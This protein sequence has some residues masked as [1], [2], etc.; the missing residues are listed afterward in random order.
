M[1]LQEEVVVAEAPV[2]A[3]PPADRFAGLVEDLPTGPAQPGFTAR[4]QLRGRLFEPIEGAEQQV[5]GK[6]LALLASR[7]E[8]LRSIAPE[9]PGRRQEW[10]GVGEPRLD[11]IEIGSGARSAVLPAIEPASV[12]HL[13]EKRLPVLAPF[14]SD[15]L[16]DASP[17]RLL[18]LDGMVERFPPVDSKVRLRSPLTD[19]RGKIIG[20]KSVLR[21]VGRERPR[22]GVHAPAPEVARRLRDEVALVPAHLELEGKAAIE[23]QIGEHPLA[24]SVNREDVRPVDVLE[25]RV[26]P[27]S[28]HLRIDPGVFSPGG[29]ELR[30]LGAFV[31]PPGRE[32]SPGGPEGFPNPLAELGRSPPR[33]N[34]TT[35]TSVEPSALLHHEPGNDA[36]ELPGLARAGARFDEGH[37]GP[38]RSG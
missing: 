38:A 18:R 8:R 36:G 29:E 22:G 5:A 23:G 1:Q 3:D 13:V 9:Q 33:V 26:E 6:L 21:R 25:S 20:P 10:I 19:P 17:R 27:P 24:K 37:A 11:R 7:G 34:V 14:G 28:R 35:R 4:A 12:P 16:H 32:P 31:R 30:G 2:F 15:F